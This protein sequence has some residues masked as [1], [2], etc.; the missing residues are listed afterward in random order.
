V[1]VTSPQIQF[2]GQF[3]LFLVAMA[4]I[5]TLVL[6]GDAV[7]T[8]GLARGALVVAF[9][10]LATTSFLHGSLLVDDAT[11]PGLLAATAGGLVVLVAGSLQWRGGRDTRLVLWVGTAFLA[12][13]GAV[14]FAEV[15]TPAAILRALGA[16]GIGIS[17]VLASRRSIVAKIAVSAATTLLLVV[18]VL[19][20]ALSAVL[21]STVE[22]QAV[23]NLE[24][25]GQSETRQIDLG[26][27]PALANAAE[28]ALVNLVG[29][30]GEPPT[31]AQ[32][33]NQDELRLRDAEPAHSEVIESEL[34]DLRR[35]DIG[36]AYLTADKSVIAATEPLGPSMFTAISGSRVVRQAAGARSNTEVSVELVLGGDPWVIAAQPVRQ[37]VEGG[38]RLL[39]VLVAVQI[40]DD[41]Y[42]TLRQVGL[43]AGTVLMFATEQTLVT[44][45]QGERPPEDA[46]HNLA[47]KV[48]SSAEPASA[49]DRHWI[50]VAQ[51]VLAGD[52]DPVLAL[53]AAD[54]T[55]VVA[56]LR[57]SLFRTLFLI[58]LG[59][60]VLALVLAAF[61]GDR[62][63]AN[64]RRLTTAAEAVQRGEEG[65]RAEIISEDE[66]GVLGGAFDSMVAAN[67]DKAAALRQAADDETRLRNRLEAVVAGVG[68]ALIAVDAEGVIT[69]FNHAAEDLVGLSATDA[70]GR[71]VEEVVKGT[72][73]DGTAF[74][75]RLQVPGWRWSTT[76]AVMSRSGEAI[77]V[78]AS[79][80]ILVGPADDLAG[81]VYVFRDLRREREVER[82]KTEFLSRVGHELRTPLAPIV[83]YATILQT[84]DATPE[85]VRE[86]AHNIHDSADR[87]A[88]IVQMLEFFAT[89]QAGRAVLRP[90]S[91]DVSGLIATLTQRWVSRAGDTHRISR[92]VSRRLV[93]VHADP[94][95]IDIS[96]DELVDNAVKF[97]PQGGAIRITADPSGDGVPGVLISVADRGKGMTADELDRAF[98][99]FAQ[100]DESDTR[101]FGGLGLGLALVREVVE[102]HGGRV[103]ASSRGPGQGSK[104]SIFLPGVPIDQVDEDSTRRARAR[105]RRP[106]DGGTDRG[107]GRTP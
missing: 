35:N 60:A 56:E 42:L 70:R 16:A 75:R 61:V 19:S 98:T 102:R 66:V 51:P 37:V 87:L 58:A 91:V 12:A 29:R 4:G 9:A 13:A 28:N 65:V 25:V 90:E 10:T 54:P 17:L 74:E 94:K 39:G 78:A 52:D 93:P 24:Q 3:V 100:G 47:R 104:F 77:P 69:D 92:R 50:L 30:T 96:L 44:G 73:D 27:E 5:T 83:G 38:T 49:V 99:E 82:M 106:V 67:E 40:L 105:H 11:D 34:R 57:E 59:G 80:G 36:L 6:R 7:V 97:S 20:V 45:D 62:I 103:D 23:L 41:D 88:R 76:G 72:A 68:E 95:W 33:R 79:A 32:A 81:G 86:L 89:S 43:D 15:D 64:L 22:D 63:G 84:R 107:L 18:L 21:S 2:A 71:R 53:I 48:I 8:R 14:S 46:V 55:T 31:Q 101:H 1:I 26:I 85:R